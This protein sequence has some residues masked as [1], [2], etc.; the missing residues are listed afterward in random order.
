MGNY[1][2]EKVKGDPGAY[3]LKTA[4]DN[5]KHATVTAHLYNETDAVERWCAYGHKT[6]DK[7]PLKEKCYDIQPHAYAE[8]E[9]NGTHFLIVR[10]E[11]GGDY[12]ELKK[13]YNNIDFKWDGHDIINIKRN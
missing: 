10:K 13:E 1:H 4:P 2:F 7:T 5:Y 6:F 12:Y 11:S 3:T 9:A 8:M